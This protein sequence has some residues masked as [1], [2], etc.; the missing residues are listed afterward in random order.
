MIGHL[1]KACPSYWH[2]GWK[3]GK[4]ISEEGLA[5]A[6]ALGKNVK[7]ELGLI[8]E[9]GKDYV[10]EG[11]C[12]F[13]QVIRCLCLSSFTSAMILYWNDTN[14][15]LHHFLVRI[16]WNNTWA[17]KLVFNIKAYITIQ[18]QKRRAFCQVYSYNAF[19]KW[20]VSRIYK[21]DSPPNR[22]MGKTWTDISQED[23][24]Q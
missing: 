14:T 13:R 1:G 2:L 5:S 6:N 12:D 19:N 9:I 24:G 15:T 23:K 4:D 11:C 16:K 22:K 10:R 18:K 20:L 21:K 7:N 3:V 17:L 8:R